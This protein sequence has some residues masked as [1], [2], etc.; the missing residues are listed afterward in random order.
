MMVI[1]SVN[2]FPLAP[3]HE[4]FRFRSGCFCVPVIYH[5]RLFPIFLIFVFILICMFPLLNIPGLQILITLKKG[6]RGAVFVAMKSPT[7][8]STLCY[9]LFFVQRR[10]ETY[11]SFWKSYF[12]LIL[13]VGFLPNPDRR[14]T[15]ENH[16]HHHQVVL[17]AQIPLILACTICPEWPSLLAGLLDGI[18][19]LHRTNEYI[20]TGQPTLVSS[21]VGV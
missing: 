18:Q 4:S 19:R 16:H 21:W 3:N 13:M 14:N 1:P 2:W 15:M 17:I 9:I 10:I 5:F 8:N 7:L 20:F 6:W 11:Q 12:Q